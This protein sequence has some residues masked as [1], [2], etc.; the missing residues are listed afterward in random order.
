MAKEYLV[1]TF[2]E[3]GALVRAVR[4]IR[5]HGFK[6]YD[7]Y[8]PFPAQ[9]TARAEEVSEEDSPIEI[10]AP[11][12]KVFTTPNRITTADFDGWV[13]Q[14]GSKFFTDSGN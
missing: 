14:R 7:V 9:L 11:A 12:D 2:A 8:A 13:E 3:P 4:M 10:L 5:A 1:A 6:I